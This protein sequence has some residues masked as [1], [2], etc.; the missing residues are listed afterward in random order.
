M[1]AKGYMGKTRVQ[2]LVSDKQNR[3]PYGLR[4]HFLLPYEDLKQSTL[5]LS[6]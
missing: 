5:S 4:K 2:A 3:R 6:S 1:G